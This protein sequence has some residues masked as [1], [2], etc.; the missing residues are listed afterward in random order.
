MI[1]IGS[2]VGPIAIASVNEGLFSNAIAIEPEPN[3]FSLLNTNVHLNKLEDKI[4]TYNLA[5]GDKEDVFLDFEL[6]K[7]NHGDH[8]VRYTEPED[9][10]KKFGDYGGYYREVIRVKSTTL[11]RIAPDLNKDDAFLWIDVQGYEG[12]L[13]KGAKNAINNK[14]PMCIELWPFGLKKLNGLNLI[15]DALKNSNY[16]KLIDLNSENVIHDFD[17]NKISE[18]YYKLGENSFMLDG[19]IDANYTDLLIY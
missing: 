1:D 17:T 6:S 4:K 10:S 7:I 12:H 13:L 16:T 2:N 8:R 9:A 5:L 11:D 19:Y 14:I 3:N 18:I 15:L